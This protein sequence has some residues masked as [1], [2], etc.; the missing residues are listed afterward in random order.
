[1]IHG[2]IMTIHKR[3]KEIYQLLQPYCVAIYLGGSR[4]NKY[5]KNPHDYDYIIFADTPE[6]MCTI[7]TI[8]HKYIRN[9]YENVIGL[10]DFIQVRTITKEEHSYG[11]YINK[12][13]KKLIGIDVEFTFDIIDKNRDEYK[14]I[15]IDTVNKIKDGYITNEKR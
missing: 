5:I 2:I 10:D 14:K 15:I 9:K 6:H 3:A 13:Q 8:L 7:R 11:S 1:M 4:V 12:L